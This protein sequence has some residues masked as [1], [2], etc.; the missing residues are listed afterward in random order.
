MKDGG[1]GESFQSCV[2]KQYVPHQQSQVVNTAWAVLALLAADYPDR[3]PIQTAIELLLKRQ[4]ATGDWDQEAIS[5][6]FNGNCM[7]TYTA[8]R[9]IFPI[10]ALNRFV[11]KYYGVDFKLIASK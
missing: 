4:L 10:W 8:Y 2:V 1:W 6:V 3:K 11:K 5:G 7:I 9:N